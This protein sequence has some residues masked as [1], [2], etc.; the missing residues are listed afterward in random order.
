MP[1]NLKP[2]TFIHTLEPERRTAFEQTLCRILST[3]LARRAYAQI[4]D[5]LPT[6]DAFGEY[7]SGCREDINGH[8]DPCPGA[9]EQF[10]TFRA[11]FNPSDL[12]IDAIVSL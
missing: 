6:A 11:S 8:L 3:D 10:N 12:E 9:V 5:G 1:P 7:G 4:I 2:K